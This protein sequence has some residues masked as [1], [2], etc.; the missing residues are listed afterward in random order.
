LKGKTASVRGLN[1]DHA[2]VYDVV[3]DFPFYRT[4]LNQI[5]KELRPERGRRYLDLGCGTGN[6]LG[7]IKGTKALF[8]G[9][10]FSAE[11]LKRAKRKAKNLVMADLHHLPFKNSCI[12]GIVNLNVF[13]QLDRPKVFI[14]EVHRILKPGGKVIISTPK[15][16]K[17][18]FRFI[19]MLIKTV[20]TSPKIFTKLGKLGE[21]SDYNKI[22][23]KIIDLKSDSFYQ[24]G[25]LEKMLKSFEIVNL[26]KTYEGQNWLVIA[27][28][29]AE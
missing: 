20:I 16:A 10:D 11:M 15:P 9:V 21:M 2:K 25:E 28:K 4:H 7:T 8:V 27:R 13:Y 5:L 14:K 18:P 26:K 6:F 3:V 19:P 1:D 29:P 12:D 22:E 17:T 24:K 23:Q